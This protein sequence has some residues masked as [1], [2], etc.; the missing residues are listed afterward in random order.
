VN[1]NNWLD[2]RGGSWEIGTCRKKRHGI[3]T[4]GS[5]GEIKPSNPE[6]TRRSQDLSF[7]DDIVI[8]GITEADA[9]GF[10]QVHTEHLFS[11]S[12][13]SRMY[14]AERFRF[15]LQYDRAIAFIAKDTN[16]QVLGLVY[17]GPEGYKKLMNR[18]ILKR[19]FWPLLRNPRLLLNR[20][21]LYKYRSGVSKIISRLKFGS[22]KIDVTSENPMP[23]VSVPRE[24]ILR[25]TGIAVLDEYSNLGIGTKLLYR[26]ERA[27]REANYGSVVLETPKANDLAIR[28]YEKHGWQRYYNGQSNPGKVDFCKLI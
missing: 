27:A 10:I 9:S 15:L 16:G 8:S 11:D 3:Y 28:F 1:L 12:E 6:S 7:I 13:F 25:L 2:N 19:I 24:P 23:F 21:F 18:F 17:G 20:E 5:N 4:S 26:F 14:L 22:K